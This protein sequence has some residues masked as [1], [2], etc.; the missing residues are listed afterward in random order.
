MRE[1]SLPFLFI[2]E[3]MVCILVNLW[4]DVSTWWM[5]TKASEVIE[6]LGITCHPSQEIND[7]R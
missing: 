5:A 6:L 2:P 7:L 4:W 1:N 3:L